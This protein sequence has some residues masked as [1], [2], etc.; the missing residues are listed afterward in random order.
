MEIIARLEEQE[1]SEFAPTTGATRTG[2][3]VTGLTEL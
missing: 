2:R 3:R 1:A